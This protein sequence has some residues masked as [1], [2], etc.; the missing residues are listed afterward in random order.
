MKVTSILYVMNL[1]KAYPT[2][3]IDDYMVY[4]ST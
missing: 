1:R 4:E 3:T 2:A